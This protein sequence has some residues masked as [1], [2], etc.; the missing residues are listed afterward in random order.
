MIRNISYRFSLEEIKV[1]GGHE[2]IKLD[3]SLRQYDEYDLESINNKISI[4]KVKFMQTFGISFEEYMQ[5]KEYINSSDYEKLHI[6]ELCNNMHRI[7]S[8]IC[9]GE[10]IKEVI[11]CKGIATILYK[12]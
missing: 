1:F 12:E 8:I 3:K 4:M 11:G 9:L 2:C 5:N 10:I 6:K 7:A